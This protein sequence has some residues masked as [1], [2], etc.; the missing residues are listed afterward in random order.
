MEEIL[1]LMNEFEKR[2][3]MS[4]AFTMYNDGSYSVKEFWDN[5]S[6]DGGNSIEELKIF[7]KET[8][9]KLDENG[10]SYS[11]CVKIE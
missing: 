11:P 1:K 4:I 3:N 2:N 10:R 7:L 5:E 6:L 8:Q 9:Y